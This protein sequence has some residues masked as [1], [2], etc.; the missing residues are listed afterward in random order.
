MCYINVTGAHA[1]CEALR[2]IDAIDLDCDDSQ[3]FSKEKMGMCF[4]AKRPIWQSEHKKGRMMITVYFDG[5]CGLCSKE[6]R[7]YQR[8][9]PAG[10]FTWHDI[11][12][13]PAPLKS[14][15]ISQEAALR[16]LHATDKSGKLYIGV[17]AFGLMWRALRY[18]AVLGWVVRLPVVSHLAS[19]AYNA[20]ADYRFKK[21]PHCQVFLDN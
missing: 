10:I 12:T 7:Y 17:A 3:K 16:R 15:A 5:K 6:I 8:I 14:L 19:F 20:F 2:W 18:W 4:F 1:L 21:L 13:D 11:A 9:A